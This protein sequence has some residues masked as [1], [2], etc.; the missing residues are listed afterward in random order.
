[1]LEFEELLPFVKNRTLRGDCS[2]AQT[3]V[4]REAGLCTDS[5]YNDMRSLEI[6]VH[7]GVRS[8]D[9][10]LSVRLRRLAAAVHLGPRTRCSTHTYQTHP[11]T[12]ATSAGGL[13][14]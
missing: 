11:C 10:Y 9:T 3:A 13:A 14:V 4:S 12:V 5:M 7:G 8:S 6:K 1:M 2:I